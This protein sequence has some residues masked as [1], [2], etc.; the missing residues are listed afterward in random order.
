MIRKIGLTGGIGSGKTTVAQYFKSKDCPVYIADQEAKLIMEQQNV[1]DQI[2]NKFGSDIFVENVLVREKLAAIVFNDPE[3]LKILNGIIHPAVKKHFEEWFLAQKNVPFIIYE[4]A[5]LFETGSY[6][7][8]DRIITVT[9]PLQTRIKRV[10]E[11][12][13][14]TNEQVEKRIAAQWTDEERLEK[15]DFIIENVHLD[16]T[17]EKTDKILKILQ[18]IQ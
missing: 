17:L 7:D 2:K 18:N 4:S 1:I 15:S 6:K 10:L 16:Q 9:A 11:R 14:T 5:I 8:F 12:D 3:K 13:H